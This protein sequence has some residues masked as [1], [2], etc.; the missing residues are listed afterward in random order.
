VVAVL[1]L[2]VGLDA[3]RTDINSINGA[4]PMPVEVFYFILDLPHLL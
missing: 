3:S 2:T 1:A 4:Q